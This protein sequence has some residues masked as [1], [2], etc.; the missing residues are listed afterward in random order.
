MAAVHDED[1]HDQ[2][3]FIPLDDVYEM[4]G[5]QNDPNKL[6]RIKEVA[7]TVN[8]TLS[9]EKDEGEWENIWLFDSVKM[10]SESGVLR[11]KFTESG[12]GLVKGL[13]RN[14]TSFQLRE[15]TKTK[16]RYTPKM[17]QLLKKDAFKGGARIPL[18]ELREKL[19]IPPDKYKR[20]DHFKAR[21]IV[22]TQKD[23]K[24]NALLSFT[25]KEKKDS[26]KVVAIDFKIHD[27]MEAIK[28]RMKEADRKAKESGK[29]DYYKVM[30]RYEIHGIEAS[31]LKP[32]IDKLGEDK[33]E[34]V[35]ERI[36]N[37]GVSPDRT[38]G[39]LITELKTEV[40][41]IKASGVAEKKE[42][43][44]TN[45]IESNR[46]WW[47]DNYHERIYKPFW[48][49]DKP[50]FVKNPPSSVVSDAYC[51]LGS[52]VPLPFSQPDFVEHVEAKIKEWSE[53]F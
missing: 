31:K 2:E 47:N 39:Y 17:F 5:I 34:K 45:L 42:I 30:D 33:V 46:K 25:F 18:D 49:A 7:N 41:K 21:V 32:Y 4:L 37:K 16:C 29:L 40:T 8:K 24:E 35:L 19:S 15:I 14:F 27:N 26:R 3:Y 10:I 50:L 52:T 23:M 9:V 36:L 53:R 12:H 6:R 38:P 22:A 20:F 13:K 51:Y 28:S 48:G 1:V 43:A 44:Q 11:V